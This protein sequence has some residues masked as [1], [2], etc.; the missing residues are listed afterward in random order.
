M[1]QPT[2]STSYSRSSSKEDVFLTTSPQVVKESMT[3]T[4]KTEDVQH[5][6]DHDREAA[7]NDE[8]VNELT[9]SFPV[10]ITIDDIAAST[11]G[12]LSC[13][14]S[15][16]NAQ[17]ATTVIER[18]KSLATGGNGSRLTVAEEN[19]LSKILAQDDDENYKDATSTR[20]VELDSLL[21]GLGY[22]IDNEE[23][24]DDGENKE[25]E[26]GDPVLRRLA[27]ERTLEKQKKRIDQ[28]LCTLL[29]EPLPPVVRNDDAS[30]QPLT[31]DHD[32]TVLTTPL[33]ED[34]IHDLIEKAKKELD[35]DKLDLADHES[36][37]LLAQSI[38]DEESSKKSST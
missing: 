10:A 29:R 14:S 33:T 1:N 23:E 15:S 12:T 38:L 6:K 11:S 34:D 32:D 2:T 18:N 27:K 3:T 35:D 37:R 30:L 21:T 7:A 24:N 28:A 8:F 26:R 19:R 4:S 9:L 5:N 20:E 22:N 13:M 36:I 25:K 16:V 17:S 31:C